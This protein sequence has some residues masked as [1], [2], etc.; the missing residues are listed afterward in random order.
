MNVHAC[1]LPWLALMFCAACASSSRG[2][3]LASLGPPHR[4]AVPEDAAVK[5]KGESVL[6]GRKG[7]LT[8]IP[9]VSKDDLVWA[10]DGDHFAYVKESAK[11]DW[12]VFV[13]NIAGDPIN[14]FAVYRRGLPRGL[15]W[16]D[17]RRLAYVAPESGKAS[18]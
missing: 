16:I 1:R 11:R 4:H 17:D 5:F 12:R 15:E 14:E 7:A 13:K 2:P 6:V 3:S 18:R 8:P 9:G 10:P